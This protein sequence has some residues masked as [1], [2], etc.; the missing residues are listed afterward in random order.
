MHPAREIRGNASTRLEGCRIALG[1]TGSI[2]AVETVKLARELARHG[3]EVVAF[4][5]SAALDILHPYAL[6]FA[7]GHEVVTELTGQVE[8]LVGAKGEVDA[9]LMAPATA[10]SVAKAALA[11]D[12]TPVTSLVST[13]L[14]HVPVVVA[15]AMHEGMLAN[16]RTSE[17]LDTLRE[18]GAAIVAPEIEESE[19][20]MASIETIREATIREL[21]EAPLAGDRVLVVNGSTIEKIDEMRVVTNQSTGRTGAAIAREAYRL[22]ADVDLWFGHGHVELPDPVPAERFVTVQDLVDKAPEA[23]DYDW[24]LVPAA[25]SDFQGKPSEGKVPSGEAQTLELE[26]TP[27]VLPELRKH[28]DDGQRLV[29]FKAEASIDEDDLVEK[30]SRFRKEN[31]LEAVVANRLEEVDVDDTRVHLITDAG[32]TAIEGSKVDVARSLLVRLA[33]EVD[34]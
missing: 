11:I 22:G 21:G 26:P 27:K 24:V 14:G 20:K 16:D 32:E 23:A 5:S 7:T 3:A 18:A 9:V 29:G 13:S 33:E 15:P 4:A 19:A 25:I 1:V 30:A 2:A 34:R 12:D 28:V 8:H 6:E 17:H 10:N 31:R